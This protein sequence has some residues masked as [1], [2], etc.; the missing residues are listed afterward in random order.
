MHGDELSYLFNDVLGVPSS[1]ETRD[2][3]M[4]D[5]MVE[6][7]TNFALTGDPTP[8]LSLG[9]KWQPL[10]PRSFNHLVLRSSPAM[11]KDGRADNR[12]FWRNLPLATNKIL[13]PEN[14][15]KEEITPVRS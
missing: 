5:L 7:W 11:R 3:F 1:E 6:L 12:D 14:F 13:Y 15:E 9:F 2:V 10:S 4:S 8:D